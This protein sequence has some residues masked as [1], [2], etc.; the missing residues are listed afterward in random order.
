[1]PGKLETERRSDHAR[2]AG[3][4]LIASTQ[5]ALWRAAHGSEFVT[6]RT[7]VATM[8]LAV[9]P[10]SLGM[11]LSHIRRCGLVVDGAR[12]ERGRNVHRTATWRLVPH[13]GS[14]RRTAESAPASDEAF[15]LFE[16]F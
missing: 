1:L 15:E 16:I 13:D 4:M 5:V 8:G 14:D 7:L 12:V 2:Q 3:A 6:A 11:H 10:R 9:T